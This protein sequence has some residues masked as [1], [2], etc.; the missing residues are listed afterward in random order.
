MLIISR[1][2]QK[3]KVQYAFTPLQTI[4]DNDQGIGEPLLPTPYSTLRTT[5]SNQ[6]PIEKWYIVHKSSI[7]DIIDTYL[8]T[9][10]NFIDKSLKYS[11][12]I[13]EY[14]FR[15]RMIRVLYNTSQSKY[16][17]FI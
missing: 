1:N 3:N 13:D 11:V 5:P 8:E 9:F 4:Q 2:K 16:K 17:N 15:Q 14:E 12:S 7:D 10:N 6:V